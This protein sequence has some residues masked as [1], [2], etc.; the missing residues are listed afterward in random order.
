[1]SALFLGDERRGV[2]RA[3]VAA[4]GNSQLCHHQRNP[5]QQYE[6]NVDQYEGATTVFTGNQRQVYVVGQTQ[7]A[8]VVTQEST[9]AGLVID[10]YQQPSGDKKWMGWTVQEITMGD[11]QRLRVTVNE[12]VGVILGHFPPE[13]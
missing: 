13:V 10:L 4:S 8:E 11:M 7:S 1:M 5:D 2:H 12:L 6:C 3:A 9:E